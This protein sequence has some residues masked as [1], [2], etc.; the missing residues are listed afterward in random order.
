MIGAL[1]TSEVVQ[2]HNLGSDVVKVFPGSLGGP[3]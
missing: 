3:G 2:A 1:T